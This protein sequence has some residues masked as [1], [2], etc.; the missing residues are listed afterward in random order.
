MPPTYH[1]IYV[2]RAIPAISDADIHDI[3][4]VSRARNEELGVTGLLL[5]ANHGF[6]Q[7]LEG[8]KDAV[9]AVFGSIE[10]DRRH[11]AV[12]ALVRETIARRSFPTWSM[13]FERPP[14]FPEQVKD[15][16]VLDEST[17]RQS[18]KNAATEVKSFIYGFVDVAS[19]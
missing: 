6:I 8:T 14:H 7:V 15:I 12:N 2:S 4:S 18:L 5:F 19:R 10:R 1:L 17:L 3:L 13:G 9:E 16:F 11:Q